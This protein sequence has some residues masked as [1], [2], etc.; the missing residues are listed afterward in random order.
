MAHTSAVEL[1]QRDL[2]PWRRYEEAALG[3]KNYWYPA[4][5]SRKIGAK[6]IVWMGD[7]GPTVPVEEDMP[8]EFTA[9]SAVIV[10]RITERKGSWRYASENGFD[11]GHAKY[12]HR[13][14]AVQTWFRALPAWSM[15]RG[16]P[17][18]NGPW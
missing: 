13:Y 15:R 6:P 9:P 14:G 5:W 18:M 1:R 16:G 12:L 11:E 7:G 17:V 2:R 4:T 8:E 3:F 10:G